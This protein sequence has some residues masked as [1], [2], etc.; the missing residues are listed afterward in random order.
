MITIKDLSKGFTKNGSAVIKAV[1]KVDMNIDAGEFV[2]ITGPSGSGKSTLLNIIGLLD[3]PDSGSYLLDG[4]EVSKLTLDEL[5]EI[6]NKKIGYVFQQFHLLP[7]TTAKENVEIPLIYS[8]KKNISGMAANALKQVG[9]QDRINHIPSELSGGQQQRVAIARALVNDPE[10][11]LADEPTGNL[12]S[13]SGLE[14]MSI[15]QRLNKTGKTIVLITH[16]QKIAEHVNRIVKIVDGRI[17]EEFS[18]DLPLDA[19]K[20]LSQFEKLQDVE[21][22]CGRN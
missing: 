7:K 19:E 1:D 18:V 4:N 22:S 13:Q 3:V 6:R 20:E 5:A 17:A 12:D 2:A 10:I 16:D 9:L 21:S 14:I 15:F 8:E 11:I